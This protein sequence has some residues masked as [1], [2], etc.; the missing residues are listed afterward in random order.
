MADELTTSQLNDLAL[1]PERVVTDEGTVQER[2]ISDAIDADRY[3]ASKSIDKPPYGVRFAKIRF[4]G[5]V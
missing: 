5:S 4:P 3:I 1:A 2:K